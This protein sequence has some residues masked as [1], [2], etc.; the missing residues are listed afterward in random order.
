MRKGMD[1]PTGRPQWETWWKAGT[2][3]LY[4]RTET[5]TAAFMKTYPSEGLLHTQGEKSVTPTPSPT[6]TPVNTNI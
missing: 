4:R 6:H 5:P 3:Q 1:I 2:E